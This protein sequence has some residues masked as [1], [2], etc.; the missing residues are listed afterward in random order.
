MSRTESDAPPA[1][2]A[3]GETSLPGITVTELRRHFGADATD[4][5]PTGTDRTG[6]DHPA[7]TDPGDPPPTVPGGR[8]QP[9]PSASAPPT[10]RGSDPHIGRHI[11]RYRIDA[12][13]ASGGMGTVYRAEQTH[14]VRRVVALKMILSGVANSRV[15]ERFHQERQTLARMDHPD[16]ARVLEADTT[17]E[18]DPYFVMEYCRGLPI[19]EFCNHHRLTID[20]RLGLLSR[21][22]RAVH[23]AHQQGF[24]HRDLKPGNILVGGSRSEPQIKIID[25]GIAK[26]MEDDSCLATDHTRAGEILGTPAFMSPEQGRGEAIDARTDVFALGALMFQL[27]TDSPPLR[28]DELKP[29]GLTEVL[30]AITDFEPQRPRQRIRRLDADERE[31]VAARRSMTSRQLSTLSADLDWIALRALAPDRMDRYAT[32]S[33]FADDLQRYLDH[34]PVTAVAPALSY[35]VRKFVRRH[36][37]AVISASAVLATVLIASAFVGYDH[38]QGMR[39]EEARVQRLHDEIS[40]I[41]D[42]AQALHRVARQ[43]RQLLEQQLPQVASSCRQ[44]TLLISEEPQLD[45]LSRR[46]DALLAMIDDDHR[47]LVLANRLTSARN[48]SMRHAT[49]GEGTTSLAFA[50]IDEMRQALIAFGLIPVQ[51][52]PDEAARALQDTPVVLHDEIADALEFWLSEAPPGAGL[53]I[54][55]NGT[56]CTVA[57]LVPG[58]AAASDGTLRPHDE[59]VAILTDDGQRHSFADMSKQQVYQALNGPPGETLRLRIRPGDAREQT[60]DLR[61]SGAETLWIRDILSRIAPDAWSRELREAALTFDI[62]RLR[63]L[64]RHDDLIDTRPLSGL[65]FLA[66]S[67]FALDER[68]TAIGCLRAAQRA[69]PHEFWANHYLGVALNSVRHDRFDHESVRY[70][71]AAVALRPGSPLPRY[72]LGQALEACGEP[73]AAL[74]F[75]RIAL[76]LDPEYDDARVAIERLEPTIAHHGSP[77]RAEPATDTAPAEPKPGASHTE[78]DLP[79]FEVR[80]RK[81][82][83]NGHFDEAMALLDETEKQTPDDP[84]IA[85]ARGVVLMTSGRFAEA[86]TVLHKAATEA[87]DDAAVRFYLGLACQY[88]GLRAEAIEQYQAAL[89]IRPDYAAVR[90]YLDGLQPPAAD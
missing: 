19:D 28:L 59:L 4:G 35:R 18:G 56:R 20:E 39:R 1:V 30:N 17:H 5:E 84:R 21:V 80:A 88:L 53:Y 68:E 78:T 9:P 77:P 50:D 82:A 25:F 86:R 90:E 72:T 23:H 65:L 49:I 14:P 34:H 57:R 46:V 75:Y 33:D 22:C 61:C 79:P 13:I 27:L 51:T 62:E 44:A 58:G 2:P 38:L 87:P 63:E 52:P 16:I 31:C 60:L 42:D 40:E 12:V 10:A 70:L 6:P 76:E 71:T 48:R 89:A 36:R 29:S 64:A 45:D 11:G 43:D 7:P 83:G 69:H 54:Q 32:A 55:H 37:I 74:E 67:L 73:T 66:G 24:V 26:A 8:Q 15:V 81:L 85:R 41:L 3:T 47:A